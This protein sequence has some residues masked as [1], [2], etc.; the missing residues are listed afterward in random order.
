MRALVIALFALLLALPGLQMLTHA[1]PIPALNENRTVA[2]LPPAAALADPADFTARLEAWF[3]DH[4]GFRALLIRAKTQFDYSVF[5]TSDRIHI[6]K[7]GWLYYRSVIDQQEPQM[8]GLLDRD[9]DAAVTTLAHLRDW[10]GARGIKLIVQ[11]TQ[12]K[13]RFYPEDLPREA[14]FARA[15][16]RFDDFRARL[17]A[18]PGISYLD[19]TPQ[20]LA[21]KNQRQIFHKTD[22]HW[23]DPAAFAAAARLVDTIAALDGRPV[24]FW[25]PRLRI[26]EHRFSGGQA[27]FMPLFH[28]PSENGLFVDP[29][30]DDSRLIHETGIG[31]FEWRKT[32]REPGP[33][34]LPGT[35]IFGDSFVDGMVRSGL[36]SHFNQIQFARLYGPEF[37]D[38]LRA[39]PPGTRYFV[40]EFIELSMP[41]WIAMKLLD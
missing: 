1:I 22:F 27:L 21:L 35:V 11:T 40:V 2:A 17:A 13:D 4:Y 3:N 19:T 20:L 34:L 9:L 23:N 26:T 6:G 41:S 39:I 18:L 36:A 37:T 33:S 31:P 5:A 15:R 25:K 28:P 7:H 10:L 14:T 8:E 12:Q 32:A 30:W 24:P 29:D 16:H 38:V